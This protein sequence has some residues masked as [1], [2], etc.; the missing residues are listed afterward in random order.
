MQLRPCANSKGN[1]KFAPRTPTSPSV[2]IVVRSS[3]GF[4]AISNFFAVGSVAA[5][6]EQGNTVATIDAGF[7]VTYDALTATLDQSAAGK[8][9]TR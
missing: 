9:R 2:P 8:V 7:C 5:S 6:R 1:V 3:S 4:G